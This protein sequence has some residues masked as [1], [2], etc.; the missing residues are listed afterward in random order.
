MSVSDD[1]KLLL[2]DNL[3]I[4]ARAQAFTPESA[5]FGALPELD[6]QAVILVITAIQEHFGIEIPDED[7]SGEMFATFGSLAEYV[8]SRCA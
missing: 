7:I 3:Q 1:L 4:G 6:S 5:L 2:A 8:T